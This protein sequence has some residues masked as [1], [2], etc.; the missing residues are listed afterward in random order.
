MDFEFDFSG[1]DD[2]VLLFLIEADPDGLAW[3]LSRVQKLIRELNETQQ[4]MK[5]LNPKC[6]FDVKR[7]IDGLIETLIQ[8]QHRIEMR[9]CEIGGF[10]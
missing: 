9:L 8:R 2:D 3:A 7:V 5:G 1:F 6:I 4:T 10:E